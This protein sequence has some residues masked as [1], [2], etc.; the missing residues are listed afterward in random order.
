MRYDVIFST[1]P[2]DDG[3]YVQ[4]VEEG[5]G[6]EDVAVYPTLYTDSESGAALT[7]N[8]DLLGLAEAHEV[9]LDSEF[10]ARMPTAF[11]TTE[12]VTFNFDD[13]GGANEVSVDGS[14]VTIDHD[15]TDDSSD[16]DVFTFGQT[17]YEVDLDSDG[18]G[19][20]DS[21]EVTLSVTDQDEGALEG[22]GSIFVQPEDDEDDENALVTD[23]EIGDDGGD[24]EIT[25]TEIY[26]SASDDFFGLESL[27]SEDDTEQAYTEFGS[28]V[29]V[30]TDDEGGVVGYVPSA[31]A[32]SGMAMTGPDG[33]LSSE[34][35]SASG[36]VTSM[37]PTYSWAAGNLDS[38]DDSEHRT[39]D[40]HL[41]LVGGPSVNSLVADLVEEDRTMPAE[42][43]TEGEGMIQRVE[44]FNDGQ[45][46]LIVAGH[47]G[48][49]TRAAGEFLA[50][51]RDHEGDLEGLDQVTISTETGQVV[52]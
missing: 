31:Q 8:V 18:E 2:G 46:A 45:D 24:E 27:D 3:E 50:N 7:D 20:D 16:S 6:A 4:L 39:S 17:Q 25:G 52:E 49:D 47:S 38:D 21:V 34:G 37:S 33:S 51:Y 36:S 41:I 22:P 44:G 11:D 28:F 32:T 14:T 15:A 29:E 13:S 9:G 12:E 26:A 48:E 19:S 23:L 43:Y 35:G 10:T 40:D 30:D 5:E 42:D 1:G